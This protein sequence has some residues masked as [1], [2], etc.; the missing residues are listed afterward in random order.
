MSL[1][2]NVVWVFLTL[3]IT[4]TRS[5]FDTPFDFSE[6]TPNNQ[7]KPIN[8]ILKDIDETNNSPHERQL[9]LSPNNSQ[10]HK[11]KAIKKT[12]SRKLDD[13]DKSVYRN[14]F[15]RRFV[16]AGGESPT[17]IPFKKSNHDT[18]VDYFKL[19]LPQLNEDDDRIEIVRDYLTE[20]MK[21]DPKTENITAYRMNINNTNVDNRFKAIYLNK[22]SGFSKWYYFDID[23]QDDKVHPEKY[24]REKYASVD[25]DDDYEYDREYVHTLNKDCTAIKDS[26]KN[27][28]KIQCTP[29]VNENDYVVKGVY[30]VMI[31]VKTPKGIKEIKR[32]YMTD[33]EMQEKAGKAKVE[34][35]SSQPKFD[36][37]YDLALKK[38]KAMNN[39]QMLKDIDR[40]EIINKSENAEKKIFAYNEAIRIKSIQQES[41]YV[42]DA[43]DAA[44]SSLS[45]NQTR[46]NAHVRTVALLR[47]AAEQINAFHVDVGLRMMNHLIDYMDKYK[48]YNSMAN[49]YKREIKVTKLIDYLDYLWYLRDKELDDK[50]ENY[51]RP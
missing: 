46:E 8:P 11:A 44:W 31:D 22:I 6:P 16:K 2:R 20:W 5:V 7:S 1:N 32:I 48:A 47:K 49:F 28:V 41:N 17:N 12:K 45:R 30:N 13:N 29:L 42:A 14:R 39:S 35:K 36:T 40:S 3:L 18:D 23:F 34:K 19:T 24:R 33:G 38:I 43:K 27:S 51:L 9:N 50:Y 15:P 10:K 25:T 21:L 26:V 37:P 4:S